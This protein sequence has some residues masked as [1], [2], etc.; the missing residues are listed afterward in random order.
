MKMSI[1][2]RFTLI[3]HFH[4]ARILGSRTIDV[5][6]IIPF[7]L[8]VDHCDTSLPKCEN[9]GIRNHKCECYCPAGFTGSLC[10]TVVTDSGNM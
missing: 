1:S 8:F 6:A 9:S 3:P 4:K 2:H 5:N 10:E 7:V